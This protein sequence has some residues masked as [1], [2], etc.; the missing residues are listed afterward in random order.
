VHQVWVP[1]LNTQFT[2]I[3]LVYRYIELFIVELD[4]IIRNLE[5]GS[6]LRA[7][8]MAEQPYYMSPVLSDW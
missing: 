3:N 1:L 2:N 6:Q 5:V 4:G 7:G 8:R